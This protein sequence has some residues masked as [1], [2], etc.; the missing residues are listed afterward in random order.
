MS[1]QVPAV[2]A[3]GG[4]TG[5]TTVDRVAD[6]TTAQVG[7]S[8]LRSGGLAQDS[9]RDWKSTPAREPGPGRTGSAIRGRGR[10][11]MAGRKAGHTPAARRRPAALSVRS[12]AAPG[13][14]RPKWQA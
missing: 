1:W 10:E 8:G 14:P 6:G 4:R 3:A 13:R 11:V 12:Q 7:E 5:A 2:R 9:R